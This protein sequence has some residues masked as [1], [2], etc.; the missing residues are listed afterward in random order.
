MELHLPIKI[1]T[2][3]GFQRS[4]LDKLNTKK[5]FFRYG[6]KIRF[7]V[8]LPIKE[9]SFL[10]CLDD[11]PTDIITNLITQE[12]SPISDALEWD[13]EE[14]FWFNSDKLINALTHLY[15]FY[16]EEEA[17]YE[18]LEGKTLS[19]FSFT[20]LPILPEEFKKRHIPISIDEYG[21]TVG[22]GDLFLITHNNVNP[23]VL[24]ILK[25]FPTKISF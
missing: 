7:Q 4:L 2:L 11:E 15:R 14:E 20:F 8:H 6:N 9:S 13:G 5:G 24:K 25:K 18:Q 12:I 23:Y 22:E 19:V 21:F 17:L 16:Y 3:T 10:F 1:R